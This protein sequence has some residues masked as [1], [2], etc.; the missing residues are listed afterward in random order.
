MKTSP[1]LGVLRGK[2]LFF[3]LG[4]SPIWVESLFPKEVELCQPNNP[5]HRPF[6]RAPLGWWVV[7]R[8]AKRKTTILSLGGT[9]RK[10]PYDIT[11]G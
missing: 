2:Y 3:E 10:D 6:L 5:G 7:Y 9:L 4:S 8:E 11:P 1:G